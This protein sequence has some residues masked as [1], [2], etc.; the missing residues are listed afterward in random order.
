MG[1]FVAKTDVCRRWTLVDFFKNT[2]KMQIFDLDFLAK[3]G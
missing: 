2:A 3:L 1:D